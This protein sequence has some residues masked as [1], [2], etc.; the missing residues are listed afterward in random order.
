MELEKCVAVQ[1]LYRLAVEEVPEH[2]YMLPLSEAE[3][4]YFWIPY[5]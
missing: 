2:D 4:R 5:S 1:W 3:V